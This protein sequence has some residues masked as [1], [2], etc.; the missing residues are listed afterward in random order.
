MG[1]LSPHLSGNPSYFSP[2][3]RMVAFGSPYLVFIVYVPSGFY[4]K[5]SL[6]FYLK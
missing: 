2:L 6:D 1:A 3:N 5:W 4:P